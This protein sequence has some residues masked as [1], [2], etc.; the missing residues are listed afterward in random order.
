M[1]KFVATAWGKDAK[2]DDVQLGPSDL[3]DALDLDDAVAKWAALPVSAKRYYPRTD[4]PPEL[5]VSGIAVT[6]WFVSPA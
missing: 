3:F 2:G 1:A 5:D 6:N 4:L